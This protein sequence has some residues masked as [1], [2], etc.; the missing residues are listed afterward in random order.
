MGNILFMRPRVL[1]NRLAT[2]SY[3]SHCLILVKKTNLNPLYELIHGTK[4]AMSKA[5]VGLLYKIKN[6]GGKV[7]LKLGTSH[8]QCI[9]I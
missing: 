7:G 2:C 5:S 4:P 3:S 8:H 9:F 6:L 1:R